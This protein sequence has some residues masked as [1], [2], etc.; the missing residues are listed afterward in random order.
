MP[1]IAELLG[2]IDSVVTPA[3]RR[4]A[5]LL[6]NP[7]DYTRMVLGTA[8]D[9]AANMNRTVAMMDDG[10]KLDAMGSVMGGLPQYTQAR[11]ALVSSLMG[12]M[13]VGM[14]IGPKA[15]TWDAAS[16]AK[17]MELEKAG[18][19]PRAIWKDTGTWKGPDG[20]WRQEIDDSGA[21]F[22][23]SVQNGKKV[24]ND[25]T[26]GS[27]LNYGPAIGMIEHPQLKAAYGADVAPNLFIKN[28]GDMFN[29][30]RGS[31]NKGDLTL[32]APAKA[33]DAKSTMLHEYQHGIQDLEGWAKGGSPQ[34][35]A[36]EKNGL[37]ARMSFLNGELSNAA[38]A[39]DKFPKG[40]PQYA[41]ARATYD[42]AMAEKMRMNSSI[43]QSDPHEAYQR[44]AGEAEARATQARMPLNAEQRRATF[45]ADSYDVPLD[46]LIF[47]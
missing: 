44:L 25:L 12:V 22:N 9:Q 29:S 39:L 43:T 6:R 3:K 41:E 1:T 23:T 28:S 26:H 18:I 2:G 42:A 7:A 30:V 13:P 47:R 21:L 34:A 32:F 20:N 19:D 36:Q 17:A 8:G 5:D 24:E 40:S 4:L 11:N 37:L 38:K 14:M 31:L 15:K 16:A 27:T 46:K 33:A 10:T 35:I 45:P